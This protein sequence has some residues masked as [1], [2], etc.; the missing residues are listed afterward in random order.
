MSI[1]LDALAEIR[2]KRAEEARAGVTLAEARAAHGLQETPKVAPSRKGSAAKA[3]KSPGPIK[4]GCYVRPK[5]EVATRPVFE[6]WTEPAWTPKEVKASN[7]ETRLAIDADHTRPVQRGAAF[8]KR[9]G[10]GGGQKCEQTRVH[11]SRG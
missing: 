3:T 2:A 11:F 5:A 9:P 6:G 10:S 4:S 8:V 7:R 1:L